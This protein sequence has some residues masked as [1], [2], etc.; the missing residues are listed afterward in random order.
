M[1]E[2]GCYSVGHADFK[3]NHCIRS[4]IHVVFDILYKILGPL[5]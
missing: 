1:I 4:I 3:F 5:N 2:N